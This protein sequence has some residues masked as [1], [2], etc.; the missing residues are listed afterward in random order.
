MC[1]VVVIRISL[2]EVSRGKPTVCKRRKAAIL[3][4][5]WRV[6][7]TPP[8]SESGAC[9]HRGDSG[10]WESHLSPC[11][12]PGMGDRVT[13][14]PGVTWSFLLAT[15]PLG[16]PRTTEAGKVSGNERQVKDPET[17]RGA[18]VAAQSTGEGGEVRPKR[19]TG[20]KAPS[21]SASAGERQG[22]DIALTNPD[23]GRPVDCGARETLRGQ[24]PL[25]L[26]NRMRALRTYGSVGGPDG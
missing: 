16:T 1:I 8:G 26:R 13:K 24:P 3:D 21:G 5:V 6:S 9:L 19:P 2:K 22:R 25:C 14:S 20:G 18:V 12:I 23:H 7:R 4:A 17:G 11:F 15:S 10:T